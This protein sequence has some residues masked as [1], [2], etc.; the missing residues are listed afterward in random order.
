MK[1]QEDVL[2]FNSL[3]SRP[4]RDKHLLEILQK[5]EV[6]IKDYNFF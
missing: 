6:A 1:G 2:V 3:E 4:G 5:M